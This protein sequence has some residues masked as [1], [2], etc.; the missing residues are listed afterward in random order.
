M[1]CWSK[2]RTRTALKVVAGMDDKG[3]LKTVPPKKEH[4]KEFMKIDKHSNVLEN[5]F[6]NFLRQYKDPTHFN[7]FKGI[8]RECGEQRHR[9]WRD[10]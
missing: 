2:L 3:K 9:Y 10:A 8:C 5:F 7:F 6:S 1:F 4:E